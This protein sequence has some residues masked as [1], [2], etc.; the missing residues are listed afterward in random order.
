MARRLESSALGDC[1]LNDCGCLGK[2]TYY[3]VGANHSILLI[4]GV[5]ENS[6][7]SYCRGPGNP[8]VDDCGPHF[9]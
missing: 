4:V 8:K 9:T 6:A 1:T 3:F 5:Q 7:L 2:S